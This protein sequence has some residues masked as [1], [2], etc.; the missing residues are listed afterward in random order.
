[1]ALLERDDTSGMRKLVRESQ[2]VRLERIARSLIERHIEEANPANQTGYG[3]APSDMTEPELRRC[4]AERRMAD[5]ARQAI[6]GVQ[7]ILSKLYRII[8]AKD[9]KNEKS[10]AAQDLLNEARSRVSVLRRAE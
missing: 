1:M 5:G 2:I 9:D 3:K 10:K 6:I 4:T 7:E 8:D